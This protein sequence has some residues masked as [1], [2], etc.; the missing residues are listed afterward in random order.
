MFG[1]GIVHWVRIVLWNI[2]VILTDGLR[3]VVRKTLTIERTARRSSFSSLSESA[4][5]HYTERTIS[6]K[7][8]S[9]YMFMV[10]VV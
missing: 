6:N 9:F 7:G 1:I 4:L 3:H 2:A 8:T 10:T 5:L